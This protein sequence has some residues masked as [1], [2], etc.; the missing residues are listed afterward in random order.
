MNDVKLTKPVEL[1]GK[2]VDT[3]NLDLESLTG[4]DVL[5]VEQELRSQQKDFNIS[6]QA[7]QVA[8]AAK[9]AKMIPD[10]LHKLGLKDFVEVTATVYLFLIGQ[11]FEQEEPSDPSA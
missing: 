7:T 6:S 4:A 11:G 1:D 8:I 5:A 9:A 2:Q 10:D 3:I